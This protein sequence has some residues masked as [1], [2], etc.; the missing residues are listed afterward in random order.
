MKKSMMLGIV[1]GIVAFMSGGYQV[2]ATDVGGIIDTDT[3]WDLSGSPYIVTGGILVDSGAT[4]TIEPGVQ[5]RFN[6]NFS[7]TVQGN[8]RALGTQGNEI[9]FT[10]NLIPQQQADWYQIELIDNIGSE[11][12]GIILEYSTYGIRVRQG[13]DNTV[14]NSVL[15]HNRQPLYSSNTDNLFVHNNHIYY[16]GGNQAVD[17][18][19]GGSVIFMNN[20]LENIPAAQA[21]NIN[22]IF[23]DVTINN[24]NFLGI[25]NYS[26]R[27]NDVQDGVIDGRYN[28]WGPETT[29][30]MNLKGAAANIDKIYD[31]YDYPLYGRVDYAEW[32]NAPNPNAYPW[33]GGVP[34]VN[35]SPVAKCGSDQAVFDTATLDG[36]ASYDPD[37]SIDLYE[38]QLEY[39]GDSTHDKTAIGV[40]PTIPDLYSGFYDVHLTVTDNEGATSTDTAVVAAAGPCVCTASTMYVESIIAETVR[41]SKGRHYGE[42]IVTVFDDYGKPVSGASVAGTF[43]GDF[44]EAGS[45]V[46]DG[47][48]I[49]VIRTTEQVKKPLY[50]FCVD[51]VGKEPLSYVPEDNVET[52]KSN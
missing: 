19:S 30:E 29:A 37:G 48:G 38:W 4:L 51:H 39:R 8:I 35:Q 6:G 21:I 11:L 47:N 5:V 41:A 31:F 42:V 10:S 16:S 17:I 34:P 28:Y 3:V 1:I 49:A 7:I 18:N 14:N 44:Y 2:H 24:V 26:V 22:G 43:T 36:S 15:R 50:E 13:S 40:N 33:A 9:L 46:T 20:T 23:N 27:I 32:L 52:C 12:S 25:A 45:G